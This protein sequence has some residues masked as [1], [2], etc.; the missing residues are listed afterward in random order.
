MDDFEEGEEEMKNFVNDTYWVFWR[1]NKHFLRQKIRIFMMLFQPIIWLTLMGNVFHKIA[2][3]PGFPASSY[4]NYM[5][6]G[7]VVMVTLFGGIYGGM[8]IIWD[9]R[10]GF[11]QKMM[12][13]PISRSAVILGKM[14]AIGTQTV[15]QVLIIFLVAIAMDVKFSAGLGGLV[16][17]MFLALL[18]CLVFAGIS[19][20]LGS[21]ATS[22][23]ALIAMANFLT[24]PLLFTSNAMMP[25][26][27]MPDWLSQ[28]AKFNPLT[29]AINP[30]RALFLTGWDWVAIAQGAALLVAL[31]LLTTFLATNLFRRRVVL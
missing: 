21:V 19:L 27:M 20:S 26:E 23:E 6:A 4:L 11:L 8:S 5:T 24:M 29:Y 14:L 28:I 12:A 7:I 10:L 16:V 13:A 2:S 22:H 9:R 17:M 18:L 31:V 15:I 1:E 30:I 25:L 3:V